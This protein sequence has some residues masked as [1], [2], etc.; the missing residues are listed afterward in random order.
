MNSDPFI[1]KPWAR[2]LKN[3]FLVGSSRSGTTWLQAMLASHPAIYT[4]IETHFF[5]TFSHFQDDGKRIRGRTSGLGAYLSSDQVNDLVRGMFWVI[6]SNLPEPDQPPQF[7]LEKTPSHCHFA[8]HILQ[9][10]PEAKFIHLVRDARMVAHSMIEMSKKPHGY[11]AP[12]TID[13]AAKKWKNSVIA[14]Q[15]IKQFVG[16]NQYYEV[17]YED[18]RKSPHHNLKLIFDWLNIPIDQPELDA[19]VKEN[20]L[21]T[22]TSKNQAGFATIIAPK[23]SNKSEHRDPKQMYGKGNYSG[24]D[25]GLTKAEK[26]LVDFI[27]GDLLLALG[28]E[29]VKTKFSI[30]DRLTISKKFRNIIHHLF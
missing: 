6:V 21:E 8:K 24:G 22:M 25:Y 4:G 26:E 7:F 18:L 3:I 28:Y 1:I 5:K 2:D 20:S 14:S 10:F 19:I 11:W 23:K 30:F 9:I 12:N 27:V 15:E 16:S 29:D 17:K 13:K